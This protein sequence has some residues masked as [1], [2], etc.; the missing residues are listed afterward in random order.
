M[1]YDSVREEVGEEQVSC[2]WEALG[3]A[4]SGMERHL[5][6]FGVS[7]VVEVYGGRCKVGVR[8]VEVRSYARLAL[9]VD[10][11]DW[12]YKNEQR[13]NRRRV[14]VRASELVRS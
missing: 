11:A 13:P 10:S 3:G 8:Q 14:T 7:C 1:I 9:D 12:G 2:T 6:L 5:G 4:G